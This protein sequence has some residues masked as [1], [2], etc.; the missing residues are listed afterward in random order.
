MISFRNSCKQ[1]YFRNEKHLI[2]CE[3][4]KESFLVFLA[5]NIAGQSTVA[6]HGNAVKIKALMRFILPVREATGHYLPLCFSFFFYCYPSCPG[7]FSFSLCGKSASYFS[8]ASGFSSQTK[9]PVGVEYSPVI[10]FKYPGI[11]SLHKKKEA[12]SPSGSP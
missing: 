11:N 3:K 4:P 12:S 9:Y 8:K 10:P 5:N 7:S 2:I 6:A 1:R